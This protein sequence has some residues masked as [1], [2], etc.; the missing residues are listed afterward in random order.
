MASILSSKTFTLSPTPC[1]RSST[2]FTLS[3]TRCVAL[4]SCAVAIRCSSCVNL[5]SLCKA[6]SISDLPANFFRNRSA[7]HSV[8]SLRVH[9]REQLTHF[10]LLELLCCE[11]KDEKHLNHDIYDDIRHFRGRGQFD[12][13]LKSSE[14]VF[15]AFEY[16]HEHAL[17][18]LYAL[19][20]LKNLVKT[21]HKKTEQEI[22]HREEGCNTREDHPRGWISLKYFE[23]VRRLG[24]MTYG[25]F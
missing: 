5:S 1:T 13:G 23:R 24:L 15:N 14:Y 4:R 9:Q 11:G 17:A 22:T 6:S 19:N 25:P 12:V 20:C 3:S 10:S 21:V 8:E 18:G 2:P 7:E 16:V